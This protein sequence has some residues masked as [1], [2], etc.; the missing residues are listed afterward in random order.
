MWYDIVGEKK[1]KK[2][3]VCSLRTYVRFVKNLT[4]GPGKR[5]GIPG[6]M[7]GIARS[8]GINRPGDSLET[9]GLARDMIGPGELTIT[10]LS[11]VDGYKKRG[12]KV[13]FTS[14]R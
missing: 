11:S 12:C 5:P 10:E 4:I 8:H 14:S 6:R 1:N 9:A 7:D 2:I 13:P 3:N